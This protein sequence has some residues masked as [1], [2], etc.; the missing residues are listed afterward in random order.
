METHFLPAVRHLNTREAY[1]T[2]FKYSVHTSQ[3]TR[4]VSATKP[5]RLM[6][7]RRAV[8][9]YCENHTEHT[10]M[11]K[12]SSYLKGN[13]LRLRCKAQP[14]NAVYF[15]NHTERTDTLLAECTVF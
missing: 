11:Y 10:N 1:G 5:N 2:E 3:E 14:V 12:L 9:V 6:L 15:E 7:F 8:A 13:T 4:Y